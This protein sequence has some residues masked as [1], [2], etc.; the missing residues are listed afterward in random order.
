MKTES[1]VWVWGRLVMRWRSYSRSFLARRLAAE[2][3][4]KKTVVVVRMWP[5]LMELEVIQTL[6]SI[7]HMIF[8]NMMNHKRVEG[9]S[10][11]ERRFLL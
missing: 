6:P 8:G 11:E 3:A 1:P 4:D 10:L 5:I 7:L 2:E 9:S